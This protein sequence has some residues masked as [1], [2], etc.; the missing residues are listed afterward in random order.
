MTPSKQA[1]EKFPLLQTLEN[2]TRRLVAICDGFRD[3]VNGFANLCEAYTRTEPAYS[4]R[5][6]VPV[7]WDN[8][9]G[10][11]VNNESSRIIRMLNREF[12]AFTPVKIDY[13]PATLRQ[14]IDSV[15]A[16]VYERINNGMYK[17]GFAG[18]QQV[19][20]YAVTRLFEALDEIE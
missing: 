20:E 2:P 8:K 6:T 16:F 7:L 12:D 9:S 18:S 19:Y 17:A 11:I 4:G 14:E 3:A 5:V 13:Y 1:I 15:N 10:R